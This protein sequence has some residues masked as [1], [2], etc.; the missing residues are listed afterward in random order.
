MKRKDK[1]EE[2]IKNIELIAQFRTAQQI[3]PDDWGV[4][5]PTLKISQETKVSEIIKWYKKENPNGKVELRLIELKIN[6][7]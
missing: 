7:K 2:L 3:S 5:H 6:N 1:A 4:Y